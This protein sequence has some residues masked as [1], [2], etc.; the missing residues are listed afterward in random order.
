MGRKGIVGEK[1]RQLYL[2]TNKIKKVKEI[3]QMEILALNI[4]II[5]LK[6]PSMD[7]LYITMVRGSNQQT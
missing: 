7:G 4:T 2:N 3:N 5:E 1:L 6:I